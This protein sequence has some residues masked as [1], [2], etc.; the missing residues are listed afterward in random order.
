MSSTLDVK[1]GRARAGAGGASSTPAAICQHHGGAPGM[2]TRCSVCVGAA[3]VAEGT[4]DISQEPITSG[5]THGRRPWLR[6]LLFCHHFSALHSTTCAPL[7]SSSM[8]SWA[9]WLGC[10]VPSAGAGRLRVSRMAES[11]NLQRETRV[12]AGT[13]CS[14]RRLLR[15]GVAASRCSRC[16]RCSHS[17]RCLAL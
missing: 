12:Q 14:W 17:A 7:L 2:H 8:Q 16:S 10:R 15:D 6:R 5:P 1:Q 9:A 11:A 4:D 3:R 13:G